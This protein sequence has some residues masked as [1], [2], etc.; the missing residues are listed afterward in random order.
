VRREKPQT[1][2]SS[3]RVA[4]PDKQQQPGSWN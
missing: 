1:K 2:D 3:P 4:C